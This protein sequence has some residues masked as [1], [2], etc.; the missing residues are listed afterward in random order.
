MVYKLNLADE[1]RCVEKQM[2]G[3][4]L[5]GSTIVRLMPAHAIEKGGASTRHQGAGSISRG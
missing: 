3:R 4:R 5:S 2:I 1:K